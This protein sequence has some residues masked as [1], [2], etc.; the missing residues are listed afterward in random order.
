MKKIKIV[1]YVFLVIFT[2]FSLF[3]AYIELSMNQIGIDLLTHLGFPLY[4]NYFLGIGRILGVIGIWQRMFPALREW[5]YAGF[6]IDYVA[7]ISSH[8]IVG[9]PVTAGFPAAMNLVILLI[10]YFSYHKLIK[11]NVKV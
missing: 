1:F 2:F 11:Q 8:A 5:A 10:I 6:V 9:D 7:A 4:F 3:G